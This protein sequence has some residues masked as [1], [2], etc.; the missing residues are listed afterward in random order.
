MKSTCP[1][2]PATPPN[3]VTRPL[4][5]W[6]SARWSPSSSRLRR[7]LIALVIFQ[8]A[9]IFF[10]FEFLSIVSMHVTP[11]FGRVSGCKVAKAKSLG[12]V[13]FPGKKGE[14]DTC[15]SWLIFFCLSHDPPVD[16][17]HQIGLMFTLVFVCFCLPCASV[18]L[19]IT[20]VRRAMRPLRSNASL[21]KCKCVPKPSSKCGADFSAVPKLAPGFEV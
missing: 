7:K 17:H 20:T 9:W 5:P 3:S 4:L 18:R 21:L 10:V 12:V 2:L 11:V 15:V 6:A 8:M 14:A 1:P 16:P 13:V 19:R